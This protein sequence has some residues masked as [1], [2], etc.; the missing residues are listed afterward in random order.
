MISDA[1]SDRSVRIFECQYVARRDL[2]QPQTVRLHQ[3]ALSTGRTRADVAEGVVT[4][5][6]HRQDAAG[7]GDLFA[8]TGID[9]LFGPIRSHCYRSSAGIHRRSVGG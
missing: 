6:T 8:P 7:P 5:A 9:R 2:L 1:L 3:D 4:V